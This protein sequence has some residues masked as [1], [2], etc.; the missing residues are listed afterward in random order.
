MLQFDAPHC[1]IES[2]PG[3]CSKLQT[4]YYTPQ[5]RLCA[6]LHLSF[7]SSGGCNKHQ[8]EYYTPQGA[9]LPVA[10][11][12]QTGLRRWVGHLPHTLSNKQTY[13]YALE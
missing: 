2:N 6:T 12:R 7:R 11:T 1:R 5:V 8:T 13:R 3:R 10:S 4:G 9:C